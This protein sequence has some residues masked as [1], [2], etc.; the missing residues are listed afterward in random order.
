MIMA[1]FM[2]YLEAE[3]TSRDAVRYGGENAIQNLMN[4]V[5]LKRKEESQGIMS[6]VLGIGLVGFGYKKYRGR[7]TAVSSE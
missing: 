5:D 7:Q 2:G 4:K 1:G 3:E 6:I